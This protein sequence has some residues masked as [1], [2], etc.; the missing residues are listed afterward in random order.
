MPAPIHVVCAVIEK[1]GFVLCAQ[2]SEHM[3]LPLKWEFPGGKIEPGEDEKAA[4]M[5]EIHEE[6]NTSIVIL[7]RM[8]EHVHVYTPEK[9][10]RLI[11]YRC[12]LAVGAILH[13]R[14]HEELRWVSKSDLLALDWAEADI[15]IV[16]DV[17]DL[18]SSL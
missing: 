9:E 2:R 7:E 4:L 1:D 17:M 6:L 13:A 8:P 15:P 12:E 16:H 10:I 18:R 14:E 5:R 11:P 3:V